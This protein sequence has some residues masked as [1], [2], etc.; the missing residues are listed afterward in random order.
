MAPLFRDYCPSS[1]PTEVQIVE[2]AC[3]VAIALGI[4]PQAWAQA[5]HAMDRYGAAV[6]V[7]V[8]AALHDTGRVKT[9]GGLLRAMVARH[10]T[11][12]LNLDRTL[13]GLAEVM[14]QP[15]DARRKSRRRGAAG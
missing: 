4:S 10:L 7:A 2:A 15:P 13:F 1:R 5:C 6:T 11:G 8:I 12:Q 9:A 14:D 3:L